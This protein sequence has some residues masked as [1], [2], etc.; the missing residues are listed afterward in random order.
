[1]RLEKSRVVEGL[2][3]ARAWSM[4]ETAFAHLR[5]TAVSRHVMN[6]AEF[7]Q[8]MADERVHKYV[9]TDESG[10][11]LALSTF[12]NAL[13]AMPLISPDF[14]AHRW[15]ELYARQRVWYLGFFAIDGAH[16]GEGLFKTV[17]AA[18]WAEL[19]EGGVAALD[20]CA[21]HQSLGLAKAIERTLRELTPAVTAECVDTQTYWVYGLDHRS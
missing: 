18:M 19:A 16:R 6:H 4:Y 10:E 15:P 2:V 21:S 3:L 11:V 5:I 1:M 7:G 20:M 9:V 8:V 12:T 13:E 14:F 17:I